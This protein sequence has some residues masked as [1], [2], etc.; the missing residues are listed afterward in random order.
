V[1]HAG[2][3]KTY[4]IE[5]DLFNLLTQ[6]LVKRTEEITRGLVDKHKSGAAH[7]DL[8]VLSAGGSSRMPMI[9]DMLKTLKGT[10]T[11]KALSP[12]QSIPG[13]GGSICLSSR[14]GP[15]PTRRMQN[16]A[17][18]RSTNCRRTCRSSRK[19]P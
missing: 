2:R 12:D 19:S 16:W 1:Q 9:D 5:R 11:S 3:R 17:T 6:H 7:L 14:A 15:A 18:A 4:Q 13:S 8:T 10:T